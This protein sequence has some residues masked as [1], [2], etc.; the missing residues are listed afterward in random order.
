MHC[1]PLIQHLFFQEENIP[2]QTLP[3]DCVATILTSIEVTFSQQQAVKVEPTN[4]MATILFPSEYKAVKL[5]PPSTIVLICYFLAKSRSLNLCQEIILPLFCYVAN[6]RPSR[7]RQPMIPKIVDTYILP[8]LL[9]RSFW[10]TRILSP[11][12]VPKIIFLS[13]YSMSKLQFGK[14]QYMIFNLECQQM[15][16]SGDLFKLCSIQ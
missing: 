14:T 15:L 6:G 12:K 2:K 1:V 7:L 16:K 8:V 10:V 3:L 5:K 9:I 11:Q 4:Q 13:S